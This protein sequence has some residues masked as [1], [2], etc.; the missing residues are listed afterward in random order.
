[1]AARVRPSVVGLALL[2]GLARGAGGQGTATVP[3]DD[4]AY[5]AIDRLVDRGLVTHIIIGQKPYSRALMAMAAREAAARLDSADVEDPASRQIDRVAVQAILEVVDGRPGDPG[6]PRERRV[7][8]SSL[9]R[10]LRLDALLTDAPT[11][12]VPANGLG[13]VEA[14][15]NTFT[16]NQFGVR[17]ASGM[18]VSAQSDHW[19]EAPHF[20]LQARPRLWFRNSRDDAGWRA[21]TELLALSG[22]AVQD[23]V[24]LTVGREYTLWSP[25]ERGGLFFGPNAPALDMIRLA[26]DAPF[27]LPGIFRGL[28]VAAATVQVADLGASVN[29][30]HSLLVSYKVTVKPASALEVGATFVNHFGGSGAKGAAAID[31][32]VDLVPLLDVFRH[33]ADSTDVNSDKLLGIEGRWRISRLAGVTLFGEMALEDFDRHR[34]YSI[35]HEDAAYSLGLVVPQLVVPALSARLG[36][37]STGIR[38]YE[39]HL[40]TNGIAARRFL[41]GD[42]LGHQARGASA[43]VRWES[44]TGAQVTANLDVEERRND[45]FDGSYVNPDQTGLV[46]R[47]VL[48][49]PAETRA[50][51]VVGASWFTRERHVVVRLSGGVERIANFA[52]AQSAATYHGVASTGIAVYP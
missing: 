10:V 1:V 34:L 32:F 22:R 7:S 24:A 13:S 50:R 21:S 23:N 20:A 14:D 37:H 39:H 3:P 45:F 12:G 31:R 15:L 40:I 51:A 26:N 29:N 36:V 27:A 9:V 47:T 6:P 18:N 8:I 48:T 43:L 19:L 11:R 5:R 17:R 42:E 25:D 33:H 49:L 28:G 4:P 44:V 30:S 41:L 52:F 35:F 38:F 16:D 46:F 2:A